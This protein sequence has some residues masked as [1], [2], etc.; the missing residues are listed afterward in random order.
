VR[1]NSRGLHSKLRCGA[2][3]LRFKTHTQKE[4]AVVR[5]Y[6]NYSV[7]LINALLLSFVYGGG[8]E[9]GLPT[10]L[11]K[12]L[13][14]NDAHTRLDA[15]RS[16]L[17]LRAD[18]AE[19]LL[20]ATCRTPA[21]NEN[22]VAATRRI[23][24]AWEEE[25][26]TNPQSAAAVER[27]VQLAR[28]PRNRSGED[29]PLGPHAAIP[30]ATVLRVLDVTPDAAA[31]YLSAKPGIEVS[32]DDYGFY[33]S[34]SLGS[35]W[36]VEPK[37]W[38]YIANLAQEPPPPYTN[39]RRNPIY[40]RV[41]G[42]LDG[43]TLSE[44]LRYLRKSLDSPIGLYFLQARIDREFLQVLRSFHKLVRLTGN[45]WSEDITDEDWGTA[46]PAWPDCVALNLSPSAS[47]KAIAAANKLDN[48][49]G[50]V[51]TNSNLVEADLEPLREHEKLST[52][53]V[54]DRKGESFIE[55]VNRNGTGKW[56]IG[57]ADD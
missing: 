35:D 55:Y 48:L 45:D 31:A 40:I 44:C 29:V 3:L 42:S 30:F 21:P 17:R 36:V 41:E 27:F 10:E 28:D 11:V 7:F 43:K 34:V 24:G 39:G 32:K 23:L 20:H 37:D 50:L 12:R 9:L 33:R 56:Q 18:A 53:C 51:L 57:K 25:S 14:S 16:L 46:I 2:W 52:L 4:V 1:D 19:A 49:L 13:H 15:E 54:R 5:K 47:T 26:W 22:V 8:S 38:L 6:C